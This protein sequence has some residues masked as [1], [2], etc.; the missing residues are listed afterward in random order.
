M[1]ATMKI[2]AQ[3][4]AVGDKM[5]TRFLT[6]TVVKAEKSIDG[7]SGI[8]TMYIVVEH[9]NGTTACKTLPLGFPVTILERELVYV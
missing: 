2:R 1:N 3:S 6:G 5:R 7:R 8:V 4:L 9:K